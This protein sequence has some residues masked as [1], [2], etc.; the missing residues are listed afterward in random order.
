MAA[1]PRFLSRTISIAVP[2]LLDA[3]E[4]S[5][6][7]QRQLLCHPPSVQNS[8]SPTAPVPT[9]VCATAET[10]QTLGWPRCSSGSPLPSQSSTVA[11]NPERYVHDPP[12]LLTYQSQTQSPERSHAT[13]PPPVLGARH[14]APLSDTSAP[15][16][17]DTLSRRPHDSFVCLPC[18]SSNTDPPTAGGLFLPAHRA[19]HPSPVFV[20]HESPQQGIGLSYPQQHDPLVGSQPIPDLQPEI[21]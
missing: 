8:H 9:A 14:A 18:R 15:T 7:S 20:S 19:G 4:C 5:V 12:P 21:K 17:N 11:E 16:L 13:I 10:P 2:F 3:G 1:P 6:G